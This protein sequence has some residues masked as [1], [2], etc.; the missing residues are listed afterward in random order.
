M[1][2][3]RRGKMLAAAA[4]AALTALLLAP[5]AAGCGNSGGSM[6]E[7]LPRRELPENATAEKILLESNKASEDVRSFEFKT[8][9]SVIVP[10]QGAQTQAS[11]TTFVNDGVCDNATGNIRATMRIVGLENFSLEYVIYDNRYYYSMANEGAWHEQ[12]SSAVAVPKAGDMTRQTSE[13][14]KNYQSI[15]R[16]DDEVV[17]GRDCYHISLVPDLQVTLENADIV[18]LVKA[19]I[20][21]QYAKQG[22]TLSEEEMEA[23]LEEVRK[24][25]VSKGVVKEYWVDKESLVI[26][27][28][29][30]SIET[31][32]ELDKDNSLSGKYVIETV[33][34]KYNVPTDIKPPEVSLKAKND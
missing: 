23:A 9:S 21:E 16:L 29:I 2:L 28:D 30:T 32:V 12:D 7:G 14:F 22:K 13:Y 20:T 24:S 4:C 19:M 34:P 5:L 18:E 6:G 17:N 26:R 25:T 10:P 3:P 1:V 8:E 11:K 27:R 33:Y 15:I 31:S